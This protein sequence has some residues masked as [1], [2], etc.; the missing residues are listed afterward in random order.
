MTNIIH[1]WAGCPKSANSKW[2]RFLAVIQRCREEGW[3]NYLVWS[4]MPDNPELIEPFR[5]A[6]CEIILQ[7]RSRG[8]FDLAS[9]WRTYRLLRRLQ[10]DIFHCHN[11]H[12]SPLMGAAFAG[13][14]ARVW[15]KL[16]MSS[17]YERGVPPRGMERIYLSNRVSS[18][19]SHR[20]LTLT[21]AVRHEFI[22][23]G[24]S[25]YKTVVIPAPVDVERFATASRNGVREKLGLT[26]SEFVITAIGHAVP[27]KG[28]DILLRAFAETART[29]P[30]MHLLLVGS[31]DEPN[32]HEFAENL[33]CMARET[34]CRECIHLLGHRADIAELLKASDIFAFPSRSDG[35]GL[36]LVEA[37]VAGLPCVASRAGGI[38]EVIQHN[39]SG[40]LFARERADELAE[41]LLRLYQDP[42]LRQ[43]LSQEAMAVAK[44]FSMQ[45]YVEQVMNCYIG[46]V[47]KE[48]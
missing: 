4:R 35:Q 22:A 32:D 44:R 48:T 12:T 41:Q 25:R 29:Y 34:G 47:R 43:R 23:Q 26:S 42:H 9:M 30:N 38:P 5:D 33:R 39:H 17:F 15:S 8:N 28:W 11:D 18:W 24:G 6:G 46:L 13:V 37:M 2:Q 1:Y 40:L 7:P 16:S 14:S 19:C 3:R 21:E 20:I 10:C 31:M 45:R 27:V 36:A